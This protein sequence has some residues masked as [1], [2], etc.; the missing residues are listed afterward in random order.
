MLEEAVQVCRAMR[1]MLAAAGSAEEHSD[2]AD[3]SGGRQRQAGGLRDPRL[4]ADP[5][6]A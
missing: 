2:W 5:A 4:A 1:E 3:G 6:P